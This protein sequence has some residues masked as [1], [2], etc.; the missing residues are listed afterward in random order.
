V[1]RGD[2]TVVEVNPFGGKGKLLPELLAEDGIM[3][4]G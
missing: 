3:L 4:L 2:V 1:E